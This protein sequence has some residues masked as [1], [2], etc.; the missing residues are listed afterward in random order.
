MT[1]GGCLR[2]LA[3]VGLAA[4]VAFAAL[5]ATWQWKPGWIIEPLIAWRHGRAGI[6]RKELAVGDDRWPYLE[7]IGGEGRPVVVVHGFGADANAMAGFATRLADRRVI[8]PDLPGFGEH[9]LPEGMVPWEDEYVA[10]LAA[11]LRELGPGPYDLVG[12]SMGGAI[13]GALAA[14]HPELVASLVLIAPAGVPAER[15]NDFFR[16]AREGENPLDIGSVEDFDRVLATVFLRPPELPPNVKRWLVERNR[17]HRATRAAILATMAPFLVG[18]LE[19]VAPAIRAPTLLV[20]GDSDRVTDP[21]AGESLAALVPG[22][23]LEIIPKAGHVPW[24]EAPAATYGAIRGFLAGSP[25]G[26]P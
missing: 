3:L 20:W 19:E 15:E 26:S 13:V 16:R 6:E 21:S 10:R 24:E 22:A 12:S 18:G 9:P 17:P 8:V 25:T 5:A 23:R 2:R 14:R 11:F 1:A 4:A 7:R